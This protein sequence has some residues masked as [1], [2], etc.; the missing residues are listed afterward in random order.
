MVNRIPWLE[1]EA[2]ELHICL[3]HDTQT[4]YVDSGF[5]IC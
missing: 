4:F 1:E 3:G 5:V 2:T